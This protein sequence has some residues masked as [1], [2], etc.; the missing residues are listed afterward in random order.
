MAKIAV[1]GAGG[2]GTAL[3]SMLH[4]HARSVVLWARRPEFTRELLDLRENRDYL[5]GVPLPDE[6]IE[7]T[8]Y[9]R[10]NAA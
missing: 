7:A 5:P 10:H 9:R 6:Q 1:L 3:A 8:R 2:W 4:Q